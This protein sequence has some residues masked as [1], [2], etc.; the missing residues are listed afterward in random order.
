MIRLAVSSGLLREIESRLRG[1][2][3]Q[4][5]DGDYLSNCDA[6]AILAPTG[7]EEPPV[8]QILQA[9]KH[10]LLSAEHCS[11]LQRLQTLTDTARQAG[12]QFVV[13]NW[14]R[15]RPSRQVIREQLDLGKLGEPGL[16]RLHHWG[17]PATPD[18]MISD[19][20]LV[21]WYSG[22]SPNVVHAVEQ[23]GLLIHLGFAPGG[24][25]LINRLFRPGQG[26]YRSLSIIASNG[27]AYADDH[28]NIQL[29]FR[30]ER[31]PSTLLCE[32]GFSFL[33]T[34][35][36]EFVQGLNTGR[37]M[38]RSVLDWRKALVVADAVRKSLA[39]RQAVVPEGL[40]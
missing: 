6:V 22:Q 19:L 34:M 25:A 3:L 9:R 26:E 24:M 36:Q 1:A 5:S 37:N 7:A 18:S 30:T 10:V 23:E 14:E 32:E 15:Y 27:A 40:D 17:I 13:A 20:D 33:T 38:S 16:I 39:T 35:V 29:L 21:L 4:S 31:S 11:S 12:V 8:E 2:A 28:Q